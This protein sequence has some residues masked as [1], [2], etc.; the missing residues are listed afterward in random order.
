MKRS[1]ED[2]LL[3]EILAGEELAD[4]RQSSLEEGLVTIRRQHRRKH[5]KSCSLAGTVGTDQAEN[6]TRLYG[7]TNM[8]DSAD[9]RKVLD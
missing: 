2:R 9:S 5:A 4:F 6:F 8:I 7:E 3:L 1:E